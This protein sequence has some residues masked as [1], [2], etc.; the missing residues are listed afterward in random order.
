[1]SE[2]LSQIYKIIN[3]IV[4]EYPTEYILKEMNINKESSKENLVKKLSD[5][6]METYFSENNETFSYVNEK[7]TGINKYQYLFD[8]QKDFKN[9]LQISGKKGQA[10]VIFE[11]NMIGINYK[12][13]DESIEKNIYFPEKIIKDIENQMYETFG[14]SIT[15]GDDKIPPIREKLG[16]MGVFLYEKYYGWY[17]QKCYYD[18]YDYTSAFLTGNINEIK[19]KLDEIIDCAIKSEDIENSDKKLIYEEVEKDKLK[20]DE[21]LENCKYETDEIYEEM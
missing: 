1:M 16:E 4:S 14:I 19:E 17:E 2:S 3:K 10:E 15:L 6:I 13:P 12:I 9:A 7:I 8:N 5:E 18:I 20:L 21:Y 11:N